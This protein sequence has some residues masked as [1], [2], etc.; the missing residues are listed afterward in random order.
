M[1][2][3]TGTPGSNG[4]N[5][6]TPTAGGDGGDASFTDSGVIGL[7]SLTYF[8]L[9]GD[10]GLGGNGTPG[11][12]ADGGNGG[13]ASITLN[14]NIAN[15]PA[16]SSLTVDM[17]ANGGDGGMG[18][19]APIGFTAGPQGNGG[20]ADVNINGNILQPNKTMSTVSLDAIA[21]GGL[22]S[23]D[24]DA[25]AT[26]N[27]NV[28]QV[29]KA[30]TVTLVA[31][32][33]TDDPSDSTLDDGN[34]NF[35]TKSATLS[36]NIVQG[37]ITTVTL[38]ADAMYSNAS[39]ALTGNIVQDSATSGTVTLEATGQHL[40]IEN[41]NITVGKNQGLNL[42]VNQ[43]DP[44]YDTIINSNTF[45]GAGTGNTFVF[46]DNGIIGTNTP[47]TGPTPDTIVIDL[48]QN[49]FTFDGK[50]NKLKNFNNVTV[51]GNNDP[52]IIGDNNANILVGGGGDDTFEGLGGNDTI[53]GGGG[54]NTAV[55]RG[56]YA[57][58]NLS[59]VHTGNLPGT[60]ADTTA[61]RDG[62]DTLTNIQY[63]QF[64]DGTYNVTTG[65]FTPN[66][67]VN[68]A[69]TGANNTVTTLEDHPY[70]FATSD[71]GFSDP[72]DNP[73]NALLAVE[74][75]T[76]PTAGSLTDNGVAVTAGQFVSAT[77]ISGGLLQFTP[78]P[79]ANGADYAD[80]TFQVEDNG[81]TAGGGVNTDPNP[82]TMTVNVTSVNDAPVGTSNTV[83]TLEDTAYVFH[84]ADFGF[85]D[86]NDN[87]PNQ[88]MAV[89]ITTLPNH[90][91]LTDNGVAVMA[92]QSVSVADINNG[93]LQFAPAANANGAAYA[94]FTFQVEDN[95]GTANGGV[96]TDPTPKTMTVNVTSVNDAPAGTDKT[97]TT[98]EDTAYT[99][100]AADFG[101]TDP[102]DNPANNFLAVEITTLPA[103]G[104]LTDNGVA[105]TAGQ[106]VSV[107]DIN[108]GKLVFTPAADANGAAYANFTFQVEDDGGTA[109]GGQNTDQSPNTM[110]LN[111]TLVGERCAGGHQQHRHHPGRH[112]P[113]PSRRPISASPIRTTARPT[114]CWRWRSPH[115][116]RWA[117]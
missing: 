60:V 70:I 103:A 113:I 52:T 47:T 94:N 22:G 13:N 15:A 46:T 105:V 20:N 40:D 98:L 90:G 82:K 97:V 106:F 54:A 108:A 39:A 34:A 96:N 37:P 49:S 88:L 111:V 80:F 110:T 48:S 3:K 67:T 107:A 53:N 19:G 1:V 68:H 43:L 102:N 117:R 85:T 99:F 101:F 10:G 28:V 69:P 16:T 11:D 41:N 32:A 30:N 66:A 73:P 26:L 8:V 6:A 42:T 84:A 57:Q 23:V 76:L 93:L 86:P 115:C 31:S 25:T 21:I 89:E 87:P 71:F 104:T 55:Y 4:S 63:L 72:N 95:G 64:S 65:V 100:A 50:T 27:G 114:I 79:N 75:T 56:A 17:T 62:T 77:D 78:A 116:R 5:G 7:D 33:T 2:T 91:I 29:S 9:G 12:G 18:G 24:G 58:Y 35:G 61:G 59:F 74:I 14:G 51:A 38:R 83:T 92:G 36:G 109:N 44:D 112:G 81:G 45:T